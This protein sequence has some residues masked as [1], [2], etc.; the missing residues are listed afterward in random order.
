MKGGA[1]S[2]S[3]IAM[4]I[5]REWRAYFHKNYGKRIKFRCYVLE[6]RGLPGYEGDAD[7][8]VDLYDESYMDRDKNELKALRGAFTGPS[9]ICLPNNDIIEFV[10]TRLQEDYPDIVFGL[11]QIRDE[12]PLEDLYRVMPN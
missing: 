9:K 1:D 7:I 2:I 10:M 5:S 3:D 6:E 4:E 8:V 11:D 12:R